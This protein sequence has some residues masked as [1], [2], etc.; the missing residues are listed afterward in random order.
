M[1]VVISN[2]HFSNFFP[3]LNA[4]NSHAVDRQWPPA[5]QLFRCQSQKKIHVDDSIYTNNDNDDVACKINN[6]NI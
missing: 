2:L 5:Y 1:F 6:D 3:T 4:R